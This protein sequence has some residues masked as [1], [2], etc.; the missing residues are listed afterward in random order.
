MNANINLL[1]LKG[2]DYISCTFL[3]IYCTSSSFLMY[4]YLTCIVQCKLYNVP[5]NLF[6]SDTYTL[7]KCLSIDLL[8]IKTSQLA[9]FAPDIPAHVTSYFELF[10]DVS[11]YDVQWI[12][13]YSTG[14]GRRLRLLYLWLE[15]TQSG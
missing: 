15:T 10:P 13:V 3:L 8:Q 12:C 4:I 6:N 9:S 5:P 1:G 2:L 7:L 11:V 14:A